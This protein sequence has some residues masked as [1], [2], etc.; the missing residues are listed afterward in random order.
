MR[1]PHQQPDH[2]KKGSVAV[3]RPAVAQSHVKPPPLGKQQ[4]LAMSWR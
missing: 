4:R 1:T 2:K 3:W